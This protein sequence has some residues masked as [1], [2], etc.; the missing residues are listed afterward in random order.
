MTVLDRFR[1]DGETAIVT[2]GDRGIG[3]AIATALAEAGA[4]VVI[5][6]RD[7]AGGEAAAA[8]TAD[9]TGAETLAVRTDV[10]DEDQVEAMVERTVEAFGGLDVLVNNAGIVVHEAAEETT[11]EEFESVLETNLTGVFLCS[12]AAVEP[13]S[14]GERDG[15]IV[16]V[17]SMSARIA[18]YPQR[19]VGYNAS[20][21]GVEGFT[22]QLASEWAERGIRVNAVAP[23]YVATE[24]AE[25]GFRDH[26]DWADTW[27][28]ETLLGE[29]ADPADVAPVALLLASE[30]SAYMTG[31]VVTVDG[32]Y[33]VR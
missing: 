3:N 1:L 4:N 2:G 32:G 9:E 8:D 33:T 28:E 30:A 18:N 25:Q 24:M 23:G 16:S 27:R 26:P 31:S 17:S 15:R 11:R 20:K 5:A 12:R 29:F 21:A 22:R 14:A 10:T 7:A 13:L 19:Q 6:N